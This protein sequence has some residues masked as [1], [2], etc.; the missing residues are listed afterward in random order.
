MPQDRIQPASLEA[1][2]SVLGCM[3][4]SESAVASACAVLEPDDF[5][6]P[7]HKEIFETAKITVKVT[8]A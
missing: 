8:V 2:Q 7:A 1:E 4:L 3:L 6:T 5:Y